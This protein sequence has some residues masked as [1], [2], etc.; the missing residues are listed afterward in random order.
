MINFNYYGLE[1]DLSSLAALRRNKCINSHDLDLT[2]A[3]AQLCFEFKGIHKCEIQETQMNIKV[4]S[5]NPI[6]MQFPQMTD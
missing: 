4:K 5:L 6:S 2:F 1:N 3:T